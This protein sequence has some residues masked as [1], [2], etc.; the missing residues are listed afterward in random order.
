MIFDPVSGSLVEWEDAQQIVASRTA[1]E[2]GVVALAAATAF[3]RKPL[4]HKAAA[5]STV[6]ASAEKGQKRD[7]LSRLGAALRRSA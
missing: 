5:A 7:L 2:A 3:A 1:N 6:T 4:A